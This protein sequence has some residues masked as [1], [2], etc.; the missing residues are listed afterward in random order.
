MRAHKQEANG[1]LA[2]LVAGCGTCLTSCTLHASGWDFCKTTSQVALIEIWFFFFPKRWFLLFTLVFRTEVSECYIR[3]LRGNVSL[4]LHNCGRL[5]QTV[6]II[7]FCGKLI[8]RG[9]VGPDLHTAAPFP[10]HCCSDSGSKI[11][12]AIWQLLSAGYIGFIFI[13][14]KEVEAGCPDIRPSPWNAQM[15]VNIL[16]L[17]HFP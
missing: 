4:A 9:W 17:I 7:C 14:R 8:H 15:T 5:L 6:K 11:I 13:R 1:S 16:L 12:R 3:K 2:P 10:D